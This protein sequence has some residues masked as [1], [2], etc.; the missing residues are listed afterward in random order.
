M[1]SNPQIND[2]LERK[3]REMPELHDKAVDELIDDLA[4]DTR[5]GGTL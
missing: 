2:F 4:R 3:Y 1:S 5:P